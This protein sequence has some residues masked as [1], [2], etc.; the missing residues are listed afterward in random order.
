MN[1]GRF[2][3]IDY[4][5]GRD[6][7]PC[8]ALLRLRIDLRTAGG[9]WWLVLGSFA[10]VE[11]ENR[12]VVGVGGEKK[13]KVRRK[14]Q[15]EELTPFPTNTSAFSAIAISTAIPTYPCSPSNFKS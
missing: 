10:R 13:K 11:R 3:E 4:S 7:W 12:D 6:L 15:E 1:M 8:V 2:T 9:R 14:G 5:T